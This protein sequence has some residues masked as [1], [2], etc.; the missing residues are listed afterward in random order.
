[1]DRATTGPGFT[2]AQSTATVERR[3]AA[4]PAARAGRHD[5]PVTAEVDRPPGRDGHDVVL[6]VRLVAEAVPNLRQVVGAPQQSLGPAETH[7]ELEVVPGRAHGHGDRLGITTR[8]L[9]PISI[10]SS[11]TS[12]SGRSIS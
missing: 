1:M 3:L 4:D 11:V 6:L 12:R 8:P 7:G 9:D 5:P 10:G 2:G